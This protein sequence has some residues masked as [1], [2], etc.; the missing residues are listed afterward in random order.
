MTRAQRWAGAALFAAVPLY[1]TLAQLDADRP[2]LPPLLPA[3]GPLVVGAIAL[4]AFA[5]LV[6]PAARIARRAEN[7]LLTL[8]FLAPGAASA[9]AALTGFDPAAGLALSLLVLAFGSTGLVL[10]CAADEAAVRLCIRA[11]LWSACAAAA[12]ALALDLS[13][14]PGAIFA[15]NNGRAIGSFLNPNELAAYALVGLGLA[16]PLALRPGRAALLAKAASVL[17]LAAL[18]ATFSRWGALC[19]VGGAAVYALAAGSGPR[20]RAAFAA[21]VAAAAMFL[22]WDAS[23]GRHHNPRDTE[24]R[25]V[26]WRTGMT[27]FLRFPL[28]GTGPLAYAKTYDVLRPPDAPGPRTPV[29]FDPHSLP[30]AF[31]A[32]GGIIA[33]GTLVTSVIVLLGALLRAARTAPRT[34]RLVALGLFAGVTALCAH[35]LINTI[36]IFF[37]LGLQGVGLG[38]A[39]VRTARAESARG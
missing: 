1:G 11:Y 22:V 24:A 35:A 36:A 29:A 20:A 38:L 14:R 17:L 8:G 23:G 4:A 39:I 33:V 27:T 21:V 37:P 25:T 2:P 18:L 19:A 28:L 31:A 15:Y 34:A 26:A 10:A 9:A 6:P 7:R 5:V 12:F 3:W 30:L 32:E 13:R 16:L